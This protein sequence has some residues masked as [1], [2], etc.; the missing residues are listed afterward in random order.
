MMNSTSELLKNVKE[1]MKKAGLPAIKESNGVDVSD[2]AKYFKARYG[3]LPK[4]LDSAF[5]NLTNALEA[6]ALTYSMKQKG[7][8]AIYKRGHLTLWEKII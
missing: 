5:C 1:K 8:T 3:P 4:G 2:R 6:L 7:Y